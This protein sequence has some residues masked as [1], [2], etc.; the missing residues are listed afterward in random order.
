MGEESSRDVLLKPYSNVRLRSLTL[1]GVEGHPS[2]G[3]RSG[4]SSRVVVRLGFLVETMQLDRGEI[5]N[6]LKEANRIR[7][8]PSRVKAAG[9]QTSGSEEPT[10]GQGAE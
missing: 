1:R 9:R 8:C 5:E 6:Y 10:V 7:N 2:R 4:G 3:V